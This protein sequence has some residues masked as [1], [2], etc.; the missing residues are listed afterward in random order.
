MRILILGEGPTDLG[1]NGPPG[2]GQLEGVLPILVRKLIGDVAPETPV[3]VG[4]QIL[5]KVRRFPEGARRMGRSQYGY[6]GKIRATLGLKEGREADAIVVVVDRDGKKNKDKIVELNKGREELRQENKACAVG[7][8]IE[9]IEAWLLADEK[10]LRTALGHRAIARLPDPESLTAHDKADND[11]PK[12]RLARLMTTALGGEIPHGDF[13]GHYAAI[14]RESAI[15]VLEERCPAG[16]RPFAE[17]VRDL[18]K[19]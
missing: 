1:R 2:T 5:G 6:A 12:G 3:E 15:S 18:L 13:P 9:M 10:A 16:F 8:A 19:G 11:H 17:Q 4:T 7:I 14:A